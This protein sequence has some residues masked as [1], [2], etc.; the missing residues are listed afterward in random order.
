MLASPRFPSPFGAPSSSLFSNGGIQPSSALPSNSDQP[1]PPH[2]PPAC[3]SSAPDFVPR[4]TAA[5]PPLPLGDHVGEPSPAPSSPHSQRSESIDDDPIQET[6]KYDLRPQRDKTQCFSTTWFDKDES[7]NYD[8]ELER[9]LSLQQRKK[10]KKPDKGK[11]PAVTQVAQQ[12]HEPYFSKVTGQ[13][14]NAPPGDVMEDIDGHVGTS[15]TL[16]TSLAHPIIFSHEGREPCDWCTNINHGISGLGERE[17]EVIEWSNGLGYT[18][19]IGGH[20]AERDSSRICSSCTFERVQILV[21]SAHKMQELEDAAHDEDLLAQYARLTSGRVSPKDR[22]CHICPTPASYGCYA[23][24]DDDAEAA[25][26][27]SVGCGL[28]MCEGCATRLNLEHEGDLKAFLTAIEIEE[29]AL[30]WRADCGFLDPEWL[31]MKNVLAELA[32]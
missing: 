6:V 9:K 26:P 8:P 1:T 18:E 5:E 20:R 32:A 22:W 13:L 17:V 19:T 4:M 31:L 28:L 16:R 3:F 14:K 12:S 25:E 11:Q 30:G 10:R 2:T 23:P 15:T 21:C 29:S 7:G 27:E 24:Q